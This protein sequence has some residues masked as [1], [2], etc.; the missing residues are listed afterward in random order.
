MNDEIKAK[1]EMRIVFMGTPDFSAYHLQSLI[2]A[3]YN[4]VGV[5]SQ[6]DKISGRGGKTRP[7]PVKVTAMNAGIDVF[8]PKSVNLKQGFSLLEQLK[9]DVIIVVAFGKILKDKVI[10][11]PGMGIYNVHASLLPAYRGAAPIQRSIEQG[12]ERTGVAIMKIATELDAGDVAK[13]SEVSIEPADNFETVHDKLQEA[14][15]TLLIDFL[16]ELRTGTVSFRK[17]AHEK[18]TYAAKIEKGELIL[19][20]TETAEKLHNKIRAFDPVPCARTLLDG[21]TVKLKG[22]LATEKGDD[23][24][25]PGTILDITKKGAWIQC[26]SGKILIKDIQLP[27]KQFTTFQEAKNGRK[28]EIGKC[29]DRV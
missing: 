25:V 9:P 28:I 14:G 7:T 1:K 20:W 17:Q 10:S 19:D 26:G 11:L 15:A 12:D 3:G 5:F 27:S 6:P 13:M 8:Q 22:S 29:F 4:I 18:A 23:T 2:D 21:Q 16:E 24:A